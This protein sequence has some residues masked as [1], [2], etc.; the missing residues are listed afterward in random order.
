MGAIV[1]CAVTAVAGRGAV[2]P[3]IEVQATHTTSTEDWL[4]GVVKPTRIVFALVFNT[5]SD[6]TVTAGVPAEAF[7]LVSVRIALHPPM[8]TPAGILL[9]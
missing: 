1:T 2:P 7:P 3:V 4:T 6:P 8:E 9:N 5:P